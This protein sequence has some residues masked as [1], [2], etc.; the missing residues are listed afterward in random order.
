MVYQVAIIVAVASAVAGFATSKTIR[1]QRSLVLNGLKYQITRYGNDTIEVARED[2]L[3]FTFDTKDGPPV[4]K[5][6][7]RA[8]LDD[9]LIQVRGALAEEAQRGGRS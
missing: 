5:V 4:L 2:G 3:R 8:Q 1:R 7:T 9:A 6:G